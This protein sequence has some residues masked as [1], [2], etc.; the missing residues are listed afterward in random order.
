MNRPLRLSIVG[1]ALSL[2]VP[3]NAQEPDTGPR[4]RPLVGRL[5][6]I[7]GAV[8]VI[9]VSAGDDGVLLVDT[10]YPETAEAVQRILQRLGGK[11]RIVVNTH[12][13]HAFANEQLATGAKIIAHDRARDR[14]REDKLM[15][16]REIPAAPPAAWPD[17]TFAD[18]LAIHFN[19]ERITLVHFPEA[20][21]DGDIAVFFQE[22]RVVIAGDIVVPMIPVTDFSSGGALEGLMAAVDAL[23]ERTPRDFTIVPGHGDLMTYEELLSYRAMVAGMIAWMTERVRAGVSLDEI[24]ASGLPSEWA[25]WNTMLPEDFVIQNFYEGVVR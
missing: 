5:H 6:L 12:W 7:E 24:L 16:D 19:G 18:S 4:S 2:T 14:L 3:A 21:T 11:P 1:I 8:D 10:G 23:I 15:Y 25:A 9:V 20:H 13:H 17:V 22:S